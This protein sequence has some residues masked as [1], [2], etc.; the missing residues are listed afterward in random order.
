MTDFYIKYDAEIKWTNFSNFTLRE[1]CPYT[2]FSWSVFS[3]IRG[4]TEYL[5]VFSPITGKYGS[6]KTTYL[7]TFHTVLI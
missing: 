5:S 6:E 1:K 4:G 2:E 3:R 7:D